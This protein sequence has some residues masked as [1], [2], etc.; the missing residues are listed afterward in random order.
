MS[1]VSGSSAALGLP[2]VDS[3]VTLPYESSASGEPPRKRESSRVKPGAC[4]RSQSTPRGRVSR[5]AKTVSVSRD[6]ACAASA[7]SDPRKTGGMNR[8]KDILRLE[9]TMRQMDEA[10]QDLNLRAAQEVSEQR[11]SVEATRHEL[12]QAKRDAA[13]VAA[14]A[15][16]AIGQVRAEAAESLRSVEAAVSRKISMSEEDMAKKHYDEVRRVES[17]HQLRLHEALR[18]MEQEKGQL[19][20]SAEL[21][22]GQLRQSAELVHSN[23]LQASSVAQESSSRLLHEQKRLAEMALEEQRRM[24][25]VERERAIEE[26][27][28]LAGVE[29]ERALEEQNRAAGVERERE[30]QEWRREVLRR[31]EETAMLQQ[32]LQQMRSMMESM[33]LQM[34][35]GAPPPPPPVG[36]S[37]QVQEIVPPRPG[38]QMQLYPHA[39][40]ELAGG[41]PPPPPPIPSS[42]PAAVA[43]RKPKPRSKSVQV[44]DPPPG[45]P[46]PVRKGHSPKSHWPHGGG[47]DGSGDQESEDDR[48]DGSDSPD[49][50]DGGQRGR[51]SRGFGAGKKEAATITLAALPAGAAGFRR[52]KTDALRDIAG[53][54]SRPSKAYKWLLK[55]MNSEVSDRR[56]NRPGTQFESLDGKML[57]ALGKVVS[58]HSF[59]QPK[60]HS[61]YESQHELTTG[62]VTLRRIFEHYS[63][64]AD[65]N[66]VYS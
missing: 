62:R 30:R 53:A 32:Q 51:G 66:G 23:V 36:S 48:S 14:S 34:A 56:L 60:L 9:S 58:A 16:S 17:E 55:V 54:S 46:R 5:R 4:K 26:Q 40:M 59:L 12:N 39:M 41:A 42:S 13:G 1:S 37:V 10:W 29:R 63:T 18:G 57:T 3:D 8:E 33:S 11:W 25:G 6:A 2:V 21:E 50:S 61:Y 45:I 27:R 15:Q 35:S 31:D 24:A 43:E 7:A 64:D 19:R 49:S 20:Q 65:M 22:K 28:R 44:C 52:W 47:G 38:G